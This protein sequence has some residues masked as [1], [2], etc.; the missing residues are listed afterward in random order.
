MKINVPGLPTP[1]PLATKDPI[2]SLVNTIST[3]VSGESYNDEVS[4]WEGLKML[5]KIPLTI[6]LILLSKFSLTYIR[7]CQWGLKTDRKP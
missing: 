2:I 4:N 6:Y 5:L 3:L 1:W 7:Y